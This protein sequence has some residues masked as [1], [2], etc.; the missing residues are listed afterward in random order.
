MKFIFKKLRQSLQGM[1]RLMCLSTE[2]TSTVT[3]RGRIY[4]LG[5]R[6]DTIRTASE[7]KKTLQRLIESI[8]EFHIL[9]NNVKMT[10]INLKTKF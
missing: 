8:K 4:Y 7:L 3:Y 10:L 2:E 1:L 6:T 5:L 9:L